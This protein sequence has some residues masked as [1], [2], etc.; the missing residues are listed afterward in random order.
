MS[1]IHLPSMSFFFRPLEFTVSLLLAEYMLA[2][3]FGTM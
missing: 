3:A 1:L 2:E